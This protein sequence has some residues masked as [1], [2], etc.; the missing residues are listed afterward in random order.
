MRFRI[1]R[2]QYT[3]LFDLYGGSNPLILLNNPKV[4]MLAQGLQS[5]GDAINAGGVSH[6]GQPIYFLWRSY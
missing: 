2:G 6:I 4:K 3:K 5:N 1:F